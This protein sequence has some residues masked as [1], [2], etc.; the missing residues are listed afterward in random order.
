M[1]IGS[2]WAEE[3]TRKAGTEMTELGTKRNQI[4]I[5]TRMVYVK[6]AKR[7]TKE[8]ET[9]TDVWKSQGLQGHGKTGNFHN[10]REREKKRNI[11]K[12]PQ[13]LAT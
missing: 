13:Q 10:H 2:D 9:A 11:R 5:R 8:M 1:E 4:R 12:V 3:K 7:N 6:D